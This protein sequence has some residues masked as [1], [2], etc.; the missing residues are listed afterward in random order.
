VR[1]VAITVDNDGAWSSGNAFDMDNAGMRAW[2]MRTGV[3]LLRSP[4][5]TQALNP[6]ENVTRRINHL[7][8]HGLRAKNLSGK[9]WAPMGVAASTQLNRQT[10]PGSSYRLRRDRTRFE[11]LT[12]RRPDMPRFLAPAGS[13]CHLRR[14]AVKAGAL[15]DTVAPGIFIRPGMS[16]GA[17]FAIDLTT[18][19]VVLTHSIWIN[20]QPNAQ[21]AAVLA[22]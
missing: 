5:H 6:V 4:A 19:R 14:E 2:R 3:D 11:I 10:I 21:W 15:L 13:P 20:P 17:F 1:L 7:I 8:N 9:V 22:I 18:L 16:G 12:G